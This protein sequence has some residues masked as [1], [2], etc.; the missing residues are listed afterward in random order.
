MIVDCSFW[1]LLTLLPEA[2]VEDIEIDKQVA[3]NCLQRQ[4]YQKYTTD[5]HFVLAGL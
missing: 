4:E 3:L 2:L 1:A 5:P